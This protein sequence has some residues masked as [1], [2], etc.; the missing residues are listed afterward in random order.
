MR[1]LLVGSHREAALL[2]LVCSIERS[3]GR[4]T[5]RTGLA[6]LPLHSAKAPRYLV[7]RLVA[8]ARCAMR[9]MARRRSEKVHAFRRLAEFERRAENMARPSSEGRQRSPE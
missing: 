6:H 7:E 1:I 2:H 9:S 4:S 3:F 5:P 8:L